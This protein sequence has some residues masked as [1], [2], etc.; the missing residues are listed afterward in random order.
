MTI[1]N[2]PKYLKK[3]M[4]VMREETEYTKKEPSRTEKHDML[5]DDFIG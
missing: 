2:R 1:V 4:S 5:N 3:N